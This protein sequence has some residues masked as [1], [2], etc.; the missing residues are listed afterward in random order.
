MFRHTQV[1]VSKLAAGHQLIATSTSIS[2]CFIAGQMPFSF[3]LH[4]EW[5]VTL[6]TLDL[7]TLS[8]L[9]LSVVAR[10]ELSAS[11]TGIAD[12]QQ[13]RRLARHPQDS[14]PFCP[15][16]LLCQVVTEALFQSLC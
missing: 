12:L 1:Q 13:G 5:W 9:V 3:R 7:G 16:S 14:S 10:C 11:R 15:V 2:L 8:H 6:E 4:L